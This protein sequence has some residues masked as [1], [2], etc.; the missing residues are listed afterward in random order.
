[1]CAVDLNKNGS[2]G[3]IVAE[4]FTSRAE[5]LTR[6]MSSVPSRVDRIAFGI[7]IVVSQ[8]RDAVPAALRS[9]ISLSIWTT[10]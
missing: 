1:M 7:A 5:M 10:A 3:T 4:P 2:E 8:H 6:A 9:R